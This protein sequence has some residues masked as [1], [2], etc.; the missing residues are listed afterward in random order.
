MN[1]VLR[2]LGLGAAFLTIAVTPLITNAQE[3]KAPA[4]EKKGTTAKKEAGTDSKKSSSG[5]V[6]I[7]EGKDG[8][9][10]FSV[11]DGENKYVGGSGPIGFESKEAA[12]KAVQSLKDTLSNAKITYPAKKADA[13]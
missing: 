11:R 4:Q 1:T 8:K 7:S 5:V 2:T 13:K 12:A 6:E 3:K 10:R 9:F